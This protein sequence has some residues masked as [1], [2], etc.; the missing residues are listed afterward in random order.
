MSGLT[1]PDV[2]NYAVGKGFLLFKPNGAVDFYHVGNCPKFTFLPKITPLPHFSAMAGSSVQDFSIIQR[3]AG[4]VT[5]DAEEMTVNN[6]AS[7]LQGDI[8]ATDPNAVTI[9]IM[10]KKS[11]IQGRLKYYGTNDVGPRWNIDLLQVQLNPTA[12]FN[13]I[14]EAYNVM[15]L[16]GLVLIQNGSWG[17]ATKLPPVSSIVPTNITQPFITGPLNEG[18]SPTFAKVGETMTAQAGG[19][20]GIATI[21]YQWKAAGVAIS[22]AD[23]VEYIPVV[24]D[25]GKALTVVITATNPNGTT[26][27]TSAATA[28][29]HS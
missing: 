12:P 29:V 18:A 4:E 11:L 28:N 19:W 9:D 3:R 1:S 7:Y 10:S 2:N 20:I 21:A 6:F 15:Q 22:G 24:G 5:I 26:V 23:G 27:V 13:P 17:T 14:S 8:D 16:Q 25:I